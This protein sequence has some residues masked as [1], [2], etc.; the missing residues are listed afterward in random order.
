[1]VTR[2]AVL[3]KAAEWVGMQERSGNNDIWFADD[4]GITGSSWCFAFVQSCFWY[5]DPT[6]TGQLP[7]QSMY[8]P[9]GVQWARDNN[10]SIEVGGAP[11]PGDVVFY[12]WGNGWGRWTP[13]TGDH[14]GI[15]E[16][17]DGGD[18]INTIEGNTG[19]NASTDYPQGVWRR[20]RSISEVVISFWRP[21]V[22]DTAPPPP[23]VVEELDVTP[24]QDAKLNEARA[25]AGAIAFIQ[26]PRDGKVWMV[27]GTMWKRHIQTPQILEGF[28]GYWGA[29]GAY[30]EIQVWDPIHIDSVPEI[31]YIT[32][33]VDSARELAR[34][35]SEALR[36]NSE[37][38]AAVLALAKGELPPP[39]RILDIEA[40]LDKA[41]GQQ[42]IE[43]ITRF[44]ARANPDQPAS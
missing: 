25:A 26:D 31:T 44:L 16:G 18:W 35:N 34:T 4:W 37:A 28:R 7:H 39:E 30:T 13:G 29:R 3:G 27:W 19:P 20:T 41:T 24:D 6:P 12:T 42:L 32:S 21:A 11:I 14:V 36:A 9:Y 10:Q 2:A 5:A 33:I 1:M 22:Y 23:P 17:W 15:V 43:A 8:V 40:S 38:L